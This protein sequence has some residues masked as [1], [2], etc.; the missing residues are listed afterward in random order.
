MVFEHIEQLKRDYTD[1]FVLVDDSRPE[2]ARFQGTPGRVKTVNMNGKALVEFAADANI[3]WYDIDVDFLRVVERPVP[4]EPEK[5]AAVAKKPAAAKA[6]GPPAAGGKKLSPLEMARLQGAAGK[7]K[8][9][10]GESPAAGKPSGEGKK[11]GTA[12]ILAAARGG[13]AGAAEPPAAKKPAPAAKEPAQMSVA[14][15]LAML[16]GEKGAAA[17]AAPQAEPAAPAA[18]EDA[19]GASQEQ[20][21]QEG[22]AQEGADAPVPATPA[23]AVDRGSMSVA[24]M[25]A[26]CR[27]HDAG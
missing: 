7:G 26:W 19:E 21:S 4:R 13:T 12:D 2:L 22:A 23:A 9:A 11:M 24:E 1:K 20:V 17:P 6:A 27:Q 10:A 8:P 15:K 25:I 14:E 3:G 5:K 18:A 16:R